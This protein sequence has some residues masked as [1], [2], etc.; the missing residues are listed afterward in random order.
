MFEVYW[1]DLEFAGLSQNRLR[2]KDSSSTVLPKTR[3][4]A[5]CGDG[6][7]GGVNNRNMAWG[8]F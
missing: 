3:K 7:Y 6:R 5:C 4:Q 2:V 1:L 8:I